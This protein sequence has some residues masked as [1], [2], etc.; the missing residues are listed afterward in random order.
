MPEDFGNHPT[1]ARV[2]IA[3]VEAKEHGLLLKS[4]SLAARPRP[5]ASSSIHDYSPLAANDP[6][7]LSRLA[8]GLLF[9]YEVCIPTFAQGRH[10]GGHCN[11]DFKL[12]QD[13]SKCDLT[14]EQVEERR[15][16]THRSFAITAPEHLDQMRKVGANDQE[17]ISWCEDNLENYGLPSVIPRIEADRAA[18][19]QHEWRVRLPNGAAEGLAKG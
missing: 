8:D 11:S 4:L 10:R 17:I 7:Y 18:G 19:R 15:S 16:G 1:A 3:P 5:G 12:K 14:P 13:P 2:S 9:E 6:P